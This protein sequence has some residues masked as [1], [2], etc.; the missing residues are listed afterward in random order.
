VK[1]LG[2]A[3]T[4]DR[5]VRFPQRPPNKEKL[6]ND[7]YKILAV[8]AAD[9]CKQHAKGTP[10]AWEWEE[11]FAELI[12][13]E[14]VEQ[15]GGLMNQAFNESRELASLISARVVIKEHFGVS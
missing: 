7:R 15:I 6:V 11:K 10:V 5:W 1:A 13:L 9:W 14:C 12:V 4:E 2:Y 3:S 8:E